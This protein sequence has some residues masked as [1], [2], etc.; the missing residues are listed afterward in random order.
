MSQWWIYNINNGPFSS[1]QGIK[2]KEAV[3]EYW[4]LYYLSVQIG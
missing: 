2:Q 1:L 3:K 4:K